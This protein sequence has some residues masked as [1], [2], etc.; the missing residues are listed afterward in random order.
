[1]ATKRA[2]HKKD[3]ILIP[4]PQT[5]LFRVGFKDGGQV[6]KELTGSYTKKQYAHDAIESYKKRVVRN[7]EA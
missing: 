5:T 7:A 4:I 6:P 2:P 3:F 1:M